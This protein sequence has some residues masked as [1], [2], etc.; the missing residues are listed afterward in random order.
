MVGCFWMI[1]V[2]Q[3]AESRKVFTVDKEVS[4]G[5]RA[6]LTSV[7][8]S[9]HGTAI[10]AIGIGKELY[11]YDWSTIQ[12]LPRI[13]RDDALM[14]LTWNGDVLWKNN[15]LMTM[16]DQQAA[17]YHIQQAVSD[18]LPTAPPKLIAFRQSTR[19]KPSL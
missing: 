16:W 14:R 5:Q 15:R 13:M 8:E 19:G 4:P 6:A 1:E 2:K 12:W 7:T 17:K 10:L 9:I 3:L 11:L 18:D